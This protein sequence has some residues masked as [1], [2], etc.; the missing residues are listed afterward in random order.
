MVAT[1]NVPFKR[2]GRIEVLRS[3]NQGDVF[4]L[5][6]SAN[7]HLQECAGRNVISIKNR[8]EI[9]VSAR[10][11]MVKITRFRVPIIFTRDVATSRVKIIGTRKR[12]ILTMR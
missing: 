3:L 1:I 10:H 2:I 4:I 11:R 12:V 9:S 7:C 5:E 6:K 8:N